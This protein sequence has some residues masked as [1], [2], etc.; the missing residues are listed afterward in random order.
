MASYSMTAVAG[1]SGGSGGAGGWTF[2]AD[3]NNQLA[4]ADALTQ[5]ANDFDSRKGEMY[6]KIDNMGN[7]WKG[8]DYN[9]FNTSAHNYD[10]ALSDF[11]DT[12]RMYAS[13]FEAISGATEQLATMLIDIVMNM[14]GSAAGGSAGTGTGGTGTGGTGTGGTGT[15]GTGTGGTGTGGTGTGGTGTGGT[16][17]G[18]TGTGGT[19]TGGTGTGGT[20]TGAATASE[21]QYEISGFT[22]FFTSNSYWGEVG[23]DFSNN[24]D[25]SN[26]DNLLDYVGEGVG[27]TI[28]SASSIVGVTGNAVFD[29][30]NT[31]LDGAQYLL[32]GNGSMTSDTPVNTDPSEFTN[33][34]NAAYWGTLGENFSENWNYSDCDN[35]MDYVVQ[36]GSGVLST[37]WD[38][39]GVV[40]NGVVDTAQGAVECV[41]W[42]WN[43]IF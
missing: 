31:L 19:G 32:F 25:F 9:L 8:E 1:G 39:A 33:P 42:L 2:I 7:Y 21:E 29:G 15:G 35:A 24:Y 18:G 38:G 30:T 22:N 34:Y 28:K 27:G 23:E 17:T 11:S 12:I 14:T 37:V 10:T 3:S 40:V 5:A 13:Q 16:G 20:G 36:T 4:L 43:K 41:E 6:G 26:C